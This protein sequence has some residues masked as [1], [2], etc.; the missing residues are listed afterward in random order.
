[1]S[2]KRTIG[3]LLASCAALAALLVVPAS[4]QAKTKFG[5]DL[6]NNDG[7][8]TQPT[9]ERNCQQD[10]NALDS[11]Q[12]CDRIAVNYQDTGA[13]DNH[14]TA[15][16]DGTIDKIKLVALHAGSF[17]LELGRAKNLNG[18]DG[19]GKIVAHGPNIDYQSSISGQDYTIQTFD[20][21]LDVSKGDDLAIK[22]KQTSLLKC[23]SG[24]TE[25]LLFQPI[26]PVGG[27]FESNLGHRS[28]CTLLLQA[29]YK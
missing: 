3:G 1:M 16:K 24:S 21:N 11:T 18:S 22:S 23:Q 27:P 2:R 28:N 14:I 8:V 6:K 13:I 26:L 9:S 25:Q 5:A 29:I 10:A 20:V 15:P 12:K 7:S 19:D 4:G 17:K